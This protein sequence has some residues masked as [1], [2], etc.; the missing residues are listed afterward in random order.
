MPVTGSPRRLFLGSSGA[1]SEIQVESSFGGFAEVQVPLSDD[2]PSAGPERKEFWRLDVCTGDVSDVF[3]QFSV[4]GLEEWCGL[5]DSIYPS[6]S[7]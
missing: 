1:L 6:S 7:T 3:Y 4:L 5:D 2:S